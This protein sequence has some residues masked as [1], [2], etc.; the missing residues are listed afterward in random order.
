MA[1]PKPNKA[2]IQKPTKP[3]KAKI[4]DRTPPGTVLPRASGGSIGPQ[5]PPELLGKF[6]GG[7]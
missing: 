3:S 6:G 2:M 5:Y 7:Q 4:V 1:K